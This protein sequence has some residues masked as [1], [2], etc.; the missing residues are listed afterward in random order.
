MTVRKTIAAAL[1]AATLT[2]SATPCLPIAQA[3]AGNIKQSA[4]TDG[5]Y[6]IG[7]ASAQEQVAYNLINQERSSASLGALTLD[8]TLCRLAR[9]K[10]QDMV[11]NRYF[12]HESPTYGNVRTMLQNAGYTF[13]GAG[14]NIARYGTL[15]KAH[16]G[17]M[18][19]SGHRRNILSSAWTKVGVGIAYD[20]NG[21]IY[22]T[23]IFA[24]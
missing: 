5:Y 8:P 7:S 13:A 4:A 14:E 9:L 20:A 17:L 16:A 12:A 15:E 1:A 22:L 23:Q 18:S 10:S 21:F 24:R 3:Q 19:S 11:D 6:T 2:V